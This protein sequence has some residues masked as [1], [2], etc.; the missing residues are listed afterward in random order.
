MTKIITRHDLPAFALSGFNAH[1]SD[2]NPALFNQKHLF[3]LYI[4]RTDTK[5]L[6]LKNGG[7]TSGAVGSKWTDTY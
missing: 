5:T 4:M 1:L 6:S 3:S 2:I 7:I